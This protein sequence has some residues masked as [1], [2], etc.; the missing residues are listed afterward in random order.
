MGQYLGRRKFQTGVYQALKSQH[1]N[2]CRLFFISACAF[3]VMTQAGGIS[4]IESSAKSSPLPRGVS[5]SLREAASASTCVFVR[6]DFARWVGFRKG[7]V[8]FGARQ[9][10]RIHGC[11]IELRS[12]EGWCK[13]HEWLTETMTS[14]SAGVVEFDRLELVA[15]PLDGP[16]RRLLAQGAEWRGRGE[17]VLSRVTLDEADGAYS[18]MRA[19]LRSE[20]DSVILRIDGQSERI[21]WKQDPPLSKQ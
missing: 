16:T 15:A 2:F 1:M 10:V 18:V 8:R 17:W 5:L 12:S 9:I 20:H 7:F 19:V 3:R 21:L 6:Y 4:L 11:S 14:A 13:L